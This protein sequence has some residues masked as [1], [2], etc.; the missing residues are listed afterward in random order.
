L[1]ISSWADFD[2][3]YYEGLSDN[4]KELGCDPDFNG[5]TM[6]ENPRPD[7]N[8]NRRGAAGHLHLGWGN[9]IPIDHPEHFENCAKMARLLDRTVGMA[10]I[11]INGDSTRREH[12]GAAGSFRPKP[13]GVEYRVPD[14]SWI[15]SKHER[16]FIF[17]VLTSTCAVLG[18]GKEDVILSNFKDDF[19]QEIINQG[20][21]QV[22][23]NSLAEQVLM[24]SLPYLHGYSPARYKGW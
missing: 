7:A 16:A 5:Y 23:N 20:N 13:Y 11:I 14:N 3:K 8:T 18:T 2:P 19:V 1:D 10:S 9:D 6:V 15:K 12:Y 24:T 22:N 4:Q 21:K 17:Q